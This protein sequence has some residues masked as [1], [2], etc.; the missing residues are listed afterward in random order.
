M[1]PLVFS[2]RVR[3]VLV[4][5]ICVTLMGVIGA[6]GMRGL[7][8]LS[9]DMTAMYQQ[10]ALAIEDLAAVQSAALQIQLQMRYIQTVRDQN[11]AASM[12]DAIEANAASLS[13]RWH[14]YFPARVADSK[15]RAAAQRVDASLAAFAKQTSEV[16]GSLGSGNADLATYEIDDLSRNGQALSAQIADLIARDTA[17][18]RGLADQGN[19]TF[20]SLRVASVC[21]MAFGVFIASVAAVSLVR[22]IARPVGSALR[23]ANQIA[24]G[25]LGNPVQAGARN[26]LG[27]LI[28]ALGAMD[29]SLADIVRGIQVSSESV[30]LASSEI[31]AGNGGLAARTE[32]QAASLEQTASSMDQLTSAVHHNADKAR[33]ASDLAAGA[34][35]AVDEGIA[36]VNRMAQTMGQ[37]TVHSSKVAEITEV[38]EGIAFQTNILALN[39]AVEAARA[40]QDGRGF[41]VVAGEV[42]SLAQRAAGAAREIKTL[43]DRSIATIRSGS[44]EAREV[45]GAIEKVQHAVRRVTQ[46]NAEISAAS[47]EQSRGIEQVN[48][49]VALMDEA[50]QRNAALV[51]QASAAALRLEEEAGAQLQLV[52][53]FRAADGSPLRAPS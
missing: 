9:A 19:E 8:R 51:E 25:R 49:A 41:A 18:V 21:V 22:T 14:G 13:T 28:E 4:L 52:S 53:V 17:R 7:S 20:G 36:L 35:A 33:Q 27:H 42:R 47:D 45:G 50:T 6:T 40:G 3:I 26:E 29:H 10:G 1:R 30:M 31:A 46:I 39:A 2:V 43:I 11:K 16:A 12:V 5:G 48:R 44:E 23:I 32:E 38:I 34:A 15:E 24:A 37:I